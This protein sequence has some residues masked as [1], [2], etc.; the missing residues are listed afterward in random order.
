[1]HKLHSERLDDRV[2][3]EPTAEYNDAAAAEQD[4]SDNTDDEAGVVLLGLFT[5]GHGHFVHDDLSLW[6]KMGWNNFSHYKRNQV[7]CAF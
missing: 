5:G 2:A 3:E 4:G 1:M 7:V 6:L